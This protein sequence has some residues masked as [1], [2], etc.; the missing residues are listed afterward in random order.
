[1]AVIVNARLKELVVVSAHLSNRNRFARKTQVT[2]IVQ[3]QES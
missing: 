3:A 2:I 1:M